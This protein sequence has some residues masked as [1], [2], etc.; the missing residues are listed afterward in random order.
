MPDTSCIVGS[1]ITVRGGA[2]RRQKS[3]RGS[4]RQDAGRHRPGTERLMRVG[5]V[6]VAMRERASLMYRGSI[7]FPILWRKSRCET[8]YWF[9]VL[10][11]SY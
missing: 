9:G 1:S 7:I 2:T 11:R 5:D 8:T 4:N 6:A 10:Y 3:K